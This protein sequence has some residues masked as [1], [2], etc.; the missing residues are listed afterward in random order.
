MFCLDSSARVRGSTH[1][2]SQFWSVLAGV[3]AVRV[4]DL[5]SVFEA[6]GFVTNA[7]TQQPPPLPPSG[8]GVGAMRGWHTEVNKPQ[9]RELGVRNMQENARERR[10]VSDGFFLSKVCLSWSTVFCRFIEILFT[11][12]HLFKTWLSSCCFLIYWNSPICLVKSC[13]VA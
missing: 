8:D 11:K 1:R 4:L 10:E 13:Y 5:V 7:Y 12:Q 2:S 6:L 9:Q 3:S